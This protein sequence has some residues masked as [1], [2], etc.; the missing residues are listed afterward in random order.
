M[1]SHELQTC[2]WPR[3]VGCDASD[4]GAATA[5]SI[6]DDVLRQ[7][8]VP[9]QYGQAHSGASA[10]TRDEQRESVVSLYP[11]PRGQTIP[12][13]PE[14]KVPPKPVITSRGQPKPFQHVDIAKV[15]SVLRG[16]LIAI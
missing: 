5:P 1:Y 6:N 16:F 9:A 10:A 8:V 7:R 15:R 12:P 4:G 3:N 2:D 14:L 11:V 13:P